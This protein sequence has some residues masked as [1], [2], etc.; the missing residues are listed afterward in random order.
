MLVGL[1]SWLEVSDSIGAGIHP[2]SMA[3]KERQ[4]T[5]LDLNE[6][7]NWASVL[8]FATDFSR[9][10]GPPGD[11]GLAVTLCPFLRIACICYWEVWSETRHHPYQ[12]LQGN[13]ITNNYWKACPM[14][15]VKWSLC[16]CPP[17]F[18]FGLFPAILPIS[19]VALVS[20]FQWDG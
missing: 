3:E 13:C 8:C 1:V 20:S 7:V 10:Q 4:K 15:S 17:C 12:W 9:C 19:H 18:L 11:S 5:C 14:N 6:T 16:Y 2:S